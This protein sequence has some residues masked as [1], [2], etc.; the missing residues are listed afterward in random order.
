ERRDAALYTFL[1]DGLDDGADRL[2][3]DREWD[4]V[5]LQA[6]LLLLGAQRSLPRLLR[7]VLR[8]EVRGSLRSPA[9]FPRL[10]AHEED[11]ARGGGQHDRDQSDVD[12]GP[13]LR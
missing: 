6:P 12:S 7:D 5:V 3:D 2:G 1:P 10:L 8:R 11:H 9:I 4:L 13:R